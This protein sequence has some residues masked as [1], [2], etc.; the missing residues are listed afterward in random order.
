MEKENEG[1]HCCLSQARQAE[2]HDLY[3]D[4][5]PSK[6]WHIEMREGG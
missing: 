3:A 6:Q 1:S 5:V 4:R 2:P